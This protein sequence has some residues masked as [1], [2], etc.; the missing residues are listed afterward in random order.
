MNDSEISRA[1]MRI[2]Q[3]KAMI[4]G[5]EQEITQQTAALD[6][7]E[8]LVRRCDDPR[9]PNA[10]RTLKPSHA[11]AWRM[12]ADKTQ[13]L[14]DDVKPKYKDAEKEIQH[15]EGQLT[16]ARADRADREKQHARLIERAKADTQI[17]RL[18]LE[19]EIATARLQIA[20]LDYNQ[21]AD[22]W[23]HTLERENYGPLRAAAVY[24]LAQLEAEH[25]TA[26]STPEEKRS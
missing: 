11:G 18:V 6:R 7:A 12:E 20:Q 2:L 4:G 26:Y 14:I 25:H 21:Q 24:R 5:W 15:L 16:H 17:D 3:L 19:R 1:E 23:T 8:N 22:G 9:T 13:A 10:I